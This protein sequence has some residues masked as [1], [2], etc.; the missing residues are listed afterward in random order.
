MLSMREAAERLGIHRPN[1]AQWLRRHLLRR[2]RDTGR[3]ILHR[4]GRG[5]YVSLA[6]LRR[7]APELVEPVDEI[8]QA[9][10]EDTKA[11]RRFERTVLERLDELSAEISLHS[12][13]M[14]KILGRSGARAG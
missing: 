1:A 9:L 4:T 13:L 3:A 2:E 7:H 6:N 14:R 12:E 8:G 10:R 5:Y 11:R